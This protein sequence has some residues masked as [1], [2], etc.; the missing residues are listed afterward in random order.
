MLHVQA[1][2]GVVVRNDLETTAA[3]VCPRL[4]NGEENVSK[5]LQLAYQLVP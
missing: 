1:A 4:P 2:L 3:G 5:R